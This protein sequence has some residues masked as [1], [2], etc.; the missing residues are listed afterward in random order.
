MYK[1]EV[2]QDDENTIE[3]SLA[4][5]GTT[6]GEDEGLDEDSFEGTGTIEDTEDEDTLQAAALA[7]AERKAKV[8]ALLNGKGKS[9]KN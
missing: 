5:Q 7:A 6:A 4:P 8:Q 1:F 2:A 3:V 9:A